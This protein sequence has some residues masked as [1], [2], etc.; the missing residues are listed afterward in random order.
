MPTF[1][2]L[3]RKRCSKQG[4]RNTVWLAGRDE[5]IKFKKAEEPGAQ[6]EEYEKSLREDINESILQTGLWRDWRHNSLLL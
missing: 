6:N 1:Q 4:S 5:A 3:T 2:F